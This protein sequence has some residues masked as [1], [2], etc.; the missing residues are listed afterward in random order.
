[1]K[2][3][4]LQLAPFSN[5]LEMLSPAMGDQ[6]RVVMSMEA[7]KPVKVLRVRGNLAYPMLSYIIGKA[8]AAVTPHVA[9]IQREQQIQL[10]AARVRP[11][12]P[13]N[14]PPI[15]EDKWPS[16]GRKFAKA[17]EEI[18]NQEVN[19]GELRPLTWD[20]LKKAGIIGGT[21]TLKEN[22]VEFDGS[23]VSALG[24]FLVG[25]PPDDIG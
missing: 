19:L 24:E 16:D 23:F 5:A 18:Y 9:S 25:E 4:N 20:L 2:L 1:M 21:P 13:E 6:A 8:R 14:E 3:T 12:M 22:E 10:A 17:M 15:P 11:E 7:E